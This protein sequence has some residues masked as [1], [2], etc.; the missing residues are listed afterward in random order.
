MIIHKKFTTDGHEPAR[1]AVGDGLYCSVRVANG[2][3]RQVIQFK[4]FTRFI[5]ASSVRFDNLISERGFLRA[6]K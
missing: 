3:C 2:W 4:Y 5:R 1:R 6:E